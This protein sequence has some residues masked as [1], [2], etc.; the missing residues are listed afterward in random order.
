[1]KNSNK[2]GLWIPIGILE[3]QN[4]DSS[5][6]FL[7]A[8]IYSLTE[9][10]NGC[11]ASNE[12]FSNFLGITKGAASKR[13]K[14]L[15]QKGYIKTNLIYD[16]KSCVGRKITK[17]NKSKVEKIE[18]DQEL[19][20]AT[21]LR[22]HPHVPNQPDSN[23]LCTTEVFPHQPS[24]TSSGKP[25]NTAIIS[26]LL[27]Q[28]NY[29]TGESDSA[30]EN[31]LNFQDPEHSNEGRKELNEFE[32]K[33]NLELESRN[34]ISTGVKKY[35]GITQ[36][37]MMTQYQAFK[38]Q[39]ENSRDYLANSTRMG[40]DILN[41]ASEKKLLL[42]KEKLAPDVY[43]AIVTPMKHYIQARKALGLDKQ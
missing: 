3:D 37:G 35:T 36:S 21:S 39:L 30:V 43:D 33:I 19:Q 14:N 15:K 9:L 25:I 10:P 42:L 6:K 2:K 26:G 23:S 1:M 38:L 22:K 18:T 5:D 32:P 7:L 16:K 8:E 34:E 29:N 27:N 20:V 13:I 4:L 11:F 41:F 24:P 31:V 12:H 17:A 40:N 28:H